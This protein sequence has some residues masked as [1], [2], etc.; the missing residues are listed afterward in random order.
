MMMN[1][2]LY[3]TTFAVFI[4]SFY[5]NFYSGTSTQEQL[6]K[7]VISPKSTI[8][9]LTKAKQDF[10]FALEKNGIS[11]IQLCNLEKE[12]DYQIL[13]TELEKSCDEQIYFLENP[14]DITR[15][16]QIEATE[17]C[18]EILIQKSCDLGK[19]ITLSVQSFTKRKKRLL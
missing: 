17:N 5:S 15:Y 13:L 18:Y 8:L 9:K 12:K 10:S 7:E 6:S 16:L 4:F 1:I 3:S 19:E 11:S 14:N 2:S